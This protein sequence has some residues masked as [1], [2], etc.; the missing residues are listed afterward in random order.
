MYHPHMIKR[1][2]FLPLFALGLAVL[3]TP[4]PAR[5]DTARGVSL[6]LKVFTVAGQLADASSTILL[7]HEGKHEAN[8]ALKPIAGRPA[9]LLATKA[10]LGVGLVALG[11]ALAR[12]GHRGA[13]KV[14]CFVG[15][16]AGFAAAGWNLRQR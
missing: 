5:A 9:V 16:G 10:A 2:T 4:S 7:L 11:D 14:V 15:G 3:A 13:G 12:H 6:G 8:P 1:S